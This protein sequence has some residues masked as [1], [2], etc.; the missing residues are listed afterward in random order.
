MQKGLVIRTLP[1]SYPNE[2]VEGSTGDHRMSAQAKM[3]LIPDKNVPNVKETS[4]DQARDRL[5]QEGFV[6]DAA[7]IVYQNHPTYAAGTVISQSPAR[8]I[9]WPKP[10]ARSLS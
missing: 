5:S 7:K 8:E 6:V 1:V 3:N 9:P 2:L 10:G 4:L